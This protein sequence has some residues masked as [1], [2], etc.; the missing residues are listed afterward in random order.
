MSFISE[1]VRFVLP[2]NHRADFARLRAQIARH[3]A[4]QSQYYGPTMQARSSL[5]VRT[6]E[7]CWV[8]RTLDLSL[9][10]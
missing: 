6:D 1:T 3:G 7:I 8:V 4:V 5:P 10:N 2:A 9:S